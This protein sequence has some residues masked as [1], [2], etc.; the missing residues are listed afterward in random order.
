[1][2][3]QH[4]QSQSQSAT[5]ALQNEQTALD[6]QQ[7]R[8]AS[9][10]LNNVQTRQGTRIQEGEQQRL[11][12]RQSRMR[13][14]RIESQNQH[15]FHEQLFGNTA[16]QQLYG[17]QKVQQIHWGTLYKAIDIAV[18]S[19]LLVGRLLSFFGWPRSDNKAAQANK[20]Q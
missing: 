15:L 12:K 1:M 11:L 4:D 10:S 5:Q 18:L 19:A 14:K 13:S 7:I 3:K 16:L 6:K 20:T 2:H 17:R 8:Q 9:K